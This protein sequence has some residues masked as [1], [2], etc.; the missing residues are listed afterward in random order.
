MPVAFFAASKNNF[1]FCDNDVD[2]GDVELGDRGDVELGDRGD[3]D[4]VRGNGFGDGNGDIDGVVDGVVD[5]DVDGD[6]FD[7]FI[8]LYLCVF[9][10]YINVVFPILFIA[11]LYL[12]TFV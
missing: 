9:K 11:C 7:V 2:S 3:V 1:V 5:G 12:G 4:I 10:K 6:C 8:K